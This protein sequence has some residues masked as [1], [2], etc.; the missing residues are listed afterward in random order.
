MAGSC[1]CHTT[2]CHF[3]AAQKTKQQNYP[4]KPNFT[5]NKICVWEKSGEQIISRK[6]DKTERAKGLGRR[7]REVMGKGSKMTA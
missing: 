2:Y 7:L 6:N 4:K 5:K 3:L 1:T